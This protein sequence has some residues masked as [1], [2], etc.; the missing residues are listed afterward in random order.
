MAKG[1]AGMTDQILF[2]NYQSEDETLSVPSLE[3]ELL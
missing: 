3:D 2:G 1:M